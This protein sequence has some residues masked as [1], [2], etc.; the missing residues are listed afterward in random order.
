M[1]PGLRVRHAFLERDNLVGVL[2]RQPGNSDPLPDYKIVADGF[3][4]VRENRAQVRD[5]FTD[6]SFGDYHLYGTRLNGER[7][8]SATVVNGKLSIKESELYKIA[9]SPSETSLAAA[10]ITGEEIETIAQHASPERALTL[11][12]TLASY[13]GW[14]W[15]A[16]LDTHS[17]ERG[18]Q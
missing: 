10:R 4:T 2:E 6:P 7:V 1:Q 14:T 18:P 5:L 3:K 12:R 15:K 17:R 11:R 9:M 8:E 13:E 16:A